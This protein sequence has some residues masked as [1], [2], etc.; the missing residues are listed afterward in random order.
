MANPENWVKG[1]RE[2]SSCPIASTLDV[3]GDKWSLL[4]VRDL[5]TGKQR[6]KQFC[7]S[8]EGVPTN[9]LAARLRKLEAQGIIVKQPYQSRP[10]RYAYTLTP[11]GRALLPLLQEMSRWANTYIEGTWTPPDAFMSMKAKP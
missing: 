11:A 7:D 10:V 3:V 5:L 8:P 4:I 1:G 6:Y 9:L 2:R